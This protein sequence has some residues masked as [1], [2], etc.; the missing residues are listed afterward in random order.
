MHTEP[1]HFSSFYL[2]LGQ[3]LQSVLQLILILSGQ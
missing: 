3:D 2:E 1:V